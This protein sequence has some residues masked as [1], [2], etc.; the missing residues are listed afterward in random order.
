MYIG[1]E[2]KCAAVPLIVTFVAASTAVRF[3][4][5]ICPVEVVIAV[6][7]VTVLP[8]YMALPVLE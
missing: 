3:A 5:V 2:T 8:L 7:Y 4:E 6:R 1:Y